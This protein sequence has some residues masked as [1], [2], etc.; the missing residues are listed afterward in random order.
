MLTIR[1]LGHVSIELETGPLHFETRTVAALLIYL[2]CQRQPVGREALAEFF[3]P[4]RPPKQA[5]SNLRVAL[6]RLRQQLADYLLITQSSVT[7]NPAATITLDI[8]HIERYLAEGNLSEGTERYT[9]DFLADFYLDSSPAFEQWALLERERLRTRVLSAYQQL[10]DRQAA[11]SQFAV[12]TNAAQRLLQLDPLHEPTHRQLMRILAQSG[13]RSAALAQYETCR[14]LLSS[15]LAVL[16]DETTTALAEQ[17]RT[18]ELERVTRWQG[19]TVTFTPEHSYTPSPPHPVTLSPLHNLPPQPTP[20]MGRGTELTQIIRLLTNP[21]CRLLTLL[22]VGG[23][24]KTRL[25]IEATQRIVEGSSA[26]PNR[27]FCDEACFVSLAP[28]EAIELLIV[29]IAQSLGLPTN[30]SALAADVAAH[31]RSRR[32]LLV[33]DNFEHLLEATETVTYLLQ[34]APQLK[35]LLTSRQR[36]HLREEWLFP[37][38]GLALTGA[39]MLQEGSSHGIAGEA[40]ALFVESAQ[41]VKPDFLAQGQET[42]IATVCRQVEGMPL[43]LEL[44]ASWVRVMPCAEIARLIQVDIDFLSTSLRNLPERHRSM[45]ALF[46]QSWRMLSPVEQGVLRRLSVFR[47]GCQLEEASA[48]T[49]ATLSLLLEL[50]D[51]SLLRANGEQRFDLHELVRQYAAEQLLISGEDEQI[52]QRHY[53]TYLQLFR[54]GDSYLRGPGAEPW[55]KRLEA[56]Q[57]NLRAALQWT[58]DEARYSDTQWLL[59]ASIWYWVI[60]GKWYEFGRWPT[61]LLPYRHLLPP[62]LHLTMLI[63]MYAFVRA[64]EE[65][66]PINRFH[67][68]IIHLIEICPHP[69]LQTAAWHFVADYYSD[70]SQS[71]AARERA[72]T[73]AR[74]ARERPT[75]GIEYGLFSDYDFI[76]GLPL[77]AFAYEL[78][79]RAFFDRATPLL[80]ECQEV[81]RHSENLYLMNYVH[82]T[83][84]RL[85]FLQNEL[86]QAHVY[87][88]KAVTLAITF[89]YGELIGLYQP[90]LALVTAYLGDRREAKRLLD[91]SLRICIELKD[92]RFL[93]QIA[94]Y[95]AEL[96]LM[97]EDIEAAEQQLHNIVNY[98]GII[99]KSIDETELF[100]V[101]ARLATAQQQYQRAATLF[102]LAEQAHSQIN[103]VI[104]GPCAPWQ[105]M[106]WRR[107]NQRC[108]QRPSPK[109]SPP[110]NNYH[111][112]IR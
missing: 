10:I 49:G 71:A 108:N 83:L 14:N 75:L 24:G 95:L 59:I 97:E 61:Q 88:Q 47:G 69:S 70:F 2:A 101:A 104:G 54:T 68:E 99:H 46:D 9:N 16:P 89:N 82:G 32:L 111:S 20:F 39:A 6:H 80:S 79:E 64:V 12:A 100:F 3:W 5:R 30:S 34:N 22:G 28:V 109:P 55:I 74:L 105:M 63:N 44:A 93:T 86:T 23:I 29:T 66:Q 84:G 48:V 43:A 98:Q 11:A 13:Q 38:S 42:A 77:W 57:D 60:T 18:G 96:A 45:R 85:A 102:G 76:L 92:K 78:V 90:T 35:I 8:V 40:G 36:L 73:A 87:L 62:S 107:Y 7:L 21:D 67:D 25:A 19:D 112:P 50:V 37:V 33:L 56:E 1:T 72:I 94:L 51:K 110:G 27:L 58:I 53:D 4:E 41:R 81:F 103:H 26:G 31:L 15:E 106:R 65:F 91:D 52:W 17:I